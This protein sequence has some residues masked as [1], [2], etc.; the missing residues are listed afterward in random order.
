[1][2]REKRAESK[3]QMSPKLNYQTMKHLSDDHIYTQV[4]I[5]PQVE[6]QN[7]EDG[8]AAAQPKERSRLQTEPTYLAE[9]ARYWAEVDHSRVDYGYPQVN[10]GLIFSEYERQNQFQLINNRIKDIRWIEKFHPRGSINTYRESLLRRK[11]CKVKINDRRHRLRKLLEEEHKEYMKK[12][13]IV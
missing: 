9:R 11:D 10:F 2:E 4:A 3:P 1:M 5:D 7:P 8:Q 13:S 12:R 6:A